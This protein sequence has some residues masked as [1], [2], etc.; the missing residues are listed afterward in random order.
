MSRGVSGKAAGRSTVRAGASLSVG[1][2]TDSC[3]GIVCRTPTATAPM[4]AAAA[5]GIHQR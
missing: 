4:V 5:S 3:C 2:M 1:A